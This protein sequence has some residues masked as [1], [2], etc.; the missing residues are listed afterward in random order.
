MHGMM[1]SISRNRAGRLNR[2]FTGDGN[3]L[4]CWKRS[5][6]LMM[7]PRACEPPAPAG[8]QTGVVA[9]PYAGRLS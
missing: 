4:S 1:R 9:P 8:V 3:P 6:D 2:E 7:P 5:C